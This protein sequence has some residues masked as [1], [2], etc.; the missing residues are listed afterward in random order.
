MRDGLAKTAKKAVKLADNRPI[1]ARGEMR[2]FDAWSL[3][4]SLLFFGY[5]TAIGA[6]YIYAEYDS[7]RRSGDARGCGGPLP[8]FLVCAGLAN[9]ALSVYRFVNVKRGA[10][11]QAAA[12]LG[13]GAFGGV[14]FLSTLGG[15][16]GRR[17]DPRDGR[18]CNHTVFYMSAVTLLFLAV[19]VP[20]LC[21]LLVVIWVVEDKIGRK[22]S[23]DVEEWTAKL[24][25]GDE[26]PT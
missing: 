17:E 1:Y 23:R 13:L 8:A 21:L 19:Y 16:D 20:L 26:K 14:V 11:L 7:G 10:L 9:A 4:L 22:E 15:L 2:W 5:L 25:D 18:Y 12:N 3:L 24:K 6:M